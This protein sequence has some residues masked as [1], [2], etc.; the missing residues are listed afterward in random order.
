MYKVGVTGRFTAI[1]SLVGD[2]PPE[3]KKPHPHDY[4]LEWC[5]HV[6]DLDARGFSLDISVLEAI[7]DRMFGFIAERVLNDIEW[8]KGKT[9]SLENLCGYLFESLSSSLHKEMDRA[10]VER[11]SLMEV[12]IWENEY[13]WAGVENVLVSD[14]S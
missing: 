8:F 3:E 14:R 12:K 2:V 6:A 11:I 10:D 5:L 4:Y 7:R 9:T 13:A 1:H